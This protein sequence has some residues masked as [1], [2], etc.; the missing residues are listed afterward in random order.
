M[1]GVNDVSGLYIG[2]YGFVLFVVSLH[3]VLSLLDVFFFIFLTL[4]W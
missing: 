1:L 4:S 3:P 2:F